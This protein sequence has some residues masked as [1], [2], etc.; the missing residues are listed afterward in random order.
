LTELADPTASKDFVFSCLEIA[1][2]NQSTV[3]DKSVLVDNIED[4]PININR[5]RG[6]KERAGSDELKPLL[7]LQNLNFFFR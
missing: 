2:H 5:S 4:F 7:L 3:V 6:D 1:L